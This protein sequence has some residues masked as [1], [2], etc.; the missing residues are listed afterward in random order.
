M[1]GSDKVV[2]NKGSDNTAETTIQNLIANA[3]LFLA[4]LAVC[5]GIYGG[6]LMMT[7]GGEED[8]MK[9]GRTILLQVAIGLV[10]IFLANSI[11]QFVLKNILTAGA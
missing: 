3:L 7:A 6:F 10:V 4:I 1:F 9:K 5:Y 11:V 2:K 8:K